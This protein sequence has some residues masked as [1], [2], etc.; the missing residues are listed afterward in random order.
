ME[1]MV[2][3][4]YHDYCHCVLAGLMLLCIC[5]HPSVFSDES[6][7]DD[8]PIDHTIKGGTILST[9]YESHSNSAERRPQ[10]AWQS[11][12]SSTSWM[13]TASY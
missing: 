13:Q 8:L 11:L 9:P 4:D 5:V 3:H 12:L 2:N 1:I 7:M 10:E 6:I